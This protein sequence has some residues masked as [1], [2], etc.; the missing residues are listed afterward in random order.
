MYFC[1]LPKGKGSA[2]VDVEMDGVAGVIVG[3]PVVEDTDAIHIFGEL[4]TRWDI[5]FHCDAAKGR[6]CVNQENVV[7]IVDGLEDM[8]EVM[9]EWLDGIICNLFRGAMDVNTE[10]HI[11]EGVHRC[12]QEGKET[13]HERCLGD[14]S[15]C[16]FPIRGGGGAALVALII[17]VIRRLG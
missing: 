13:T 6:H 16:W 15:K 5:M 2:D 4:V 8:Q 17:V 3:M 7:L 14:Q 10:K 11:A 12:I 9:D 1:K